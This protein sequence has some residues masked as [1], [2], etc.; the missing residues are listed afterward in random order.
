MLPLHSVWLQDFHNSEVIS[1]SCGPEAMTQPGP[2]S[3]SWDVHLLLV[4]ID[5]SELTVAAVHQRRLKAARTFARRIGMPLEKLGNDTEWFSFL[6]EY[7]GS[8]DSCLGM[9]SE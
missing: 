6:G 2:T 1:N 4:G 5:P 8:S 3:L 9:R 7:L